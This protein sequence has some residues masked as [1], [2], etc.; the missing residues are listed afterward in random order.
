MRWSVLS[1]WVSR[2][3][4][5]LLLVLGACSTASEE[6]APPLRSAVVDAYLETGLSENVASCVVGLGERQVDLRDLDPSTPTPI[7]TQEL[8]DEIVLS[9]VDA[10]KLGNPDFDETPALAF[11]SEP[12]VFGDDKM[13]DELWLWCEAGDGAACDELWETAPIGSHY[14]RFGVTCGERFDLLDCSEEL[15]LAPG[16]TIDRTLIDPPEPEPEEEEPDEEAE[17][18][19]TEPVETESVDESPV[20]AEAFT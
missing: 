20:P 5:G 19:E 8:I 10:E 2:G 11:S 6:A 4:F 13:L 14:E 1:R 9:C 3:V 7:E 18:V 16:T 15:E 12:D 17:P